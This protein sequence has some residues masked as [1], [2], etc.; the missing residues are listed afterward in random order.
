[1]SEHQP[2]EAAEG[3]G[4]ARPLAGV[5]VIDFGQIYNASYATLLMALAGADVIKVE[6]LGGESLRRRKTIKVG[7]AGL[8][9]YI[10]NSNKRGITL[11]LKDP[12]GKALLLELVD[13]A[14]V[15]VEN[16]RPGVMDRL[17]IGAD[18]LLARKPS[19]IYAAGSGYGQRGVY[20]DLPAMDVTVQA[21]AGVMASTGFPENPPVKA[22]PAVADFFGGIHL[23]GAITTALYQLALTG[24]GAR[25]DVAML[26]SVYPALVSNVGPL[27]GATSSAPRARTGNRHGG[28]AESPY[29]VYPTSDGYVSV[30]CISETHWTAILSMMGRLDLAD[31]PRFSTREA[32]VLAMQDVDELITE[33]TSTRE[34]DEVFKLLREG[35]VPSAP[36]RQLRDV[37]YDPHLRER[38]MI[39]DHDVPGVGMLPLIHS[40]LHFA[41]EARV[42]LQVAPELGE[43]ND[44]VYGTWL[45]HSA[46]ELAVLRSDGVI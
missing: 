31:D 41:G 35:G 11:N 34:T 10:M 45:G 18:A 9:F 46:D 24:K 28:L 36:V 40:P 14:T 15:V 44:E 19:L 42:P 17:G 23:Y 22:G 3:P 30:I 7:G 4:P 21:M 29:N 13:R 43:H 33:W 20:R 12:R 38:G 37:V 6:P 5:V 8:S 2:I 27:V 16:F 1:L 32:R 26:D 39:E 25:L